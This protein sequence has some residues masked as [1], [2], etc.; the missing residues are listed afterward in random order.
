MLTTRK[1][2]LLTVYDVSRSEA[3]PMHVH[4]PPYC[5]F[6]SNGDGPHIGQ[7]FLEYTSLPGPSFGM[8]R[9]SVLGEIQHID[10][11]SAESQTSAL[12]VRWT[13]EV[14]TLSNN[15]SEFTSDIGP[16]GTQEFSE[17]DLFPIYDSMLASFPHLSSINFRQKYF[18]CTQKI[19]TKLKYRTVKR[20][21]SYLNIL[22]LT[23]KI[24]MSRLSIY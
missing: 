18:G 22:L 23:G 20:F 7:T 14:E 10:I 9:M 8:V 13:H 12:E 17:V 11:S 2:A 6:P 1:N 19:S 3:R 16:L 24:L 4:S 5:L 21:M 15:L